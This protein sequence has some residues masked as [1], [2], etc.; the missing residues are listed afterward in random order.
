MK[1]NSYF[2]K[3]PCVQQHNEEDCGAACIASIAKYFGKNFTLNNIREVTGTGRQGTTLLGL[4]R[5]AEALGFNTL[6]VKANPQTINQKHRLLPSIIH[7]KGEHFVVLYGKR[8]NKYVVGDP[9]VGIRYLT[10]LELKEGWQTNI[11]L[12]LTPDF[13]RFYGQPDDKVGG[14]GRFL[15]Q[16]FAYHSLLTE[17]LFINLVIG[18]LGLA[19]PLLIQFL[20]DDVLVRGDT[21]LLTRMAIAVIVMHFVSSSGTFIQSWLI[22]WFSQ[23]I[24]LSLILEFARQILRLPLTYYEQHRSGEIVSRLEDISVINQLISQ[25]IINL[26]SKGFIGLI[27]TGLMFFYNYKLA[28]LSIVMAITMTLSTIIFYPILEQKTRSLMIL[29]NENQGILVETFKG[30][31]TLKTTTA[32]PQFWEEFQIRFTRLGNLTLDTLKIVITNDVFSDFVANIGSIVLLWYG[33]TLVISQELSIGQ[34]L[35]FYSLNGN[36]TSFVET[37]VKFF[38]E[39]IRAKTAI[40]RLTEVIDAKAET[41]NDSKKAWIKLSG[42][43]DIIC[44]NINFY[45]P[46]KVEVLQNFSLKIPGSKVVAIIGQSGCGKSTLAKLIAGLYSLELEQTN[47]TNSG[48]IFLG[49]VNLNDL[50]L[51]CLRQQVI[52]VPQ[53]A[54]FWS[55]SILENFRLGSPHLTEEQ[56]FSACE[57][58]GAHQFISRLPNG[59]Q[60]VLGEF[61]ANLS[62]G[63][64]QRLAI[65]RAIVNEPPILILDEST[66]AL[67]PESESQVL[68]N[69]LNHRKGK[70]TI[71]ISHREQVFSRSDW[72]ILLGEGRLLKEG[73]PNDLK[74]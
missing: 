29:G 56:I 18:L 64:K 39:F 65:A 71:M 10:F 74:N 51:D 12:N 63:Q 11:I 70:T 44:E 21:I 4:K 49:K 15:K 1:N 67:D 41:K 66:G 40:Q 37:V 8:G 38:D 19:S 57:L 50:A 58:T 6:S 62:G 55:R 30:A 5:G 33:S 9:G 52:L 69:L 23:K 28:W 26:P 34:L 47:K 36:L 20:T 43:A 61:G 17:A 32:F 53:D 42:N 14:F 7:W 25:A 48:N 35:A 3:F 31:M 46:G 59:Y 24:E 73:Y 2:H 22:G 13:L 68:E 16:V 27:A 72:I 45:Y 54:H 60:T